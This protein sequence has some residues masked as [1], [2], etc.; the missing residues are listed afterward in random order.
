[1]LEQPS[2]SSVRA[3]CVLR[4]SAGTGLRRAWLGLVCASLAACGGGSEQVSVAVAANFLTPLRA[5]EAEFE[6]ATGHELVL[7]SGSTG[8]LYA[9]IANGAPFDVLLAAD[10]ERPKRLADEGLGVP[11]S[12]FTYAL[13]RLA[14]WSADPELVDASTLVSLVELDVRWIAIA[15]PELAP[16]GAA[17]RQVLESLGVWD[18]LQ[19][20]M[21][22]GQ[23][24]AQ[25]FTL[26][27][28]RNADVGFVALSQALDYENGASYAVVSE[29]LHGPIRQ[30]AVLLR[31]GQENPA[32]RELMEFL[33]GPAAVSIIERQGYAAPTA[34]N[35][36]P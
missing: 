31:R 22:T 21:V 2:L 26:V 24:V 32:A 25:T 6:T 17:A 11:S 27:V 35:A 1:M 12:V 4:S 36:E 7:I 16:Y 29:A 33:R 5:I 20:R 34:A 10:A 30:D 23:N 18:A 13:G 15:N 8:Q 3:V 9:Q 19:P 14:L 28:T